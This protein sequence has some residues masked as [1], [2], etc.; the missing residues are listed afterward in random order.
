MKTL[1]MIGTVMVATEVPFSKLTEGK[2]P[3]EQTLAYVLGLLAPGMLMEDR[4]HLMYHFGGSCK[5][6]SGCGTVGE[7]DM[8]GILMSFYVPANLRGLFCC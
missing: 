3:G 6:W 5:F 1:R 4:Q 2:S 8:R 7:A